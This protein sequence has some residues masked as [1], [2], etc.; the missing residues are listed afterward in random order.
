[1]T[2]GIMA[3]VNPVSANGKTGKNW[4]RYA[5]YFQDEG[6]EMEVS[7]TEY[8][9]HATELARKAV[10]EG[11]RKIMSVGGDGTTNEVVNGLYKD[12]KLLAE[13]IKLIIFSQG[14]G[15]DFIRTFGIGKN[16][17]DIV[18]IIREEKMK[19]VDICQVSYRNYAGDIESRLFLNVADTGIGA[20]TAKL[21]NESSKIYGGFLSYLIGV[22][23]VLFTYNNKAMR[24]TIDGRE[25][26]NQ[27][28]NSVIIANGKYFGGGVMIAPEAELENGELNI[29]ILKNFSKPGIVFNLA[30]AYKGTHLSHPLVDSIKGKEISIELL[31]DGSAELELDGELVGELPA[32][33]RIVKDKLPVMG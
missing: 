11:Y 23:R 12:G 15:C 16:I 22:F 9:G 6:I 13:D 1:M 32:S 24:I 28:L 21:V 3:I 27:Y 18:N 26:Y 30:K 17:E 7:F 4:P 33:F 29:I 20:V 10:A 14:T 25:E 19:K 31:E 2:Q 5:K 8:P